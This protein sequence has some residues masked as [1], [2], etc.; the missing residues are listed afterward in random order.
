MKDGRWQFHTEE[1]LLDIDKEQKKETINYI[2]KYL[3]RKQVEL[4]D[5]ELFTLGFYVQNGL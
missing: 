3:F 4:F 5:M 1:L 2:K